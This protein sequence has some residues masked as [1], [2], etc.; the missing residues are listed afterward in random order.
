MMYAQS[1]PWVAI[2]AFIVGSACFVGL[3]VRALR[4]GKKQEG[5]WI[6]A[7]AMAML[8][9]GLALWL[10]WDKFANV[11]ISHAISFIPM[12]AM[13]YCVIQAERFRL[14]VPYRF[15]A[16]MV[17]LGIGFVV[18]GLVLVHLL[19]FPEDPWVVA[20][21][22]PLVGAAAAAIFVVDIILHERLHKR[23]MQ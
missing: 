20:I 6:A 22:N 14:G 23:S 8:G 3:S 7:G 21:A 9:I 18:N 2:V 4:R 1:P 16:S 12:Y 15:T 5:Q 11:F 10:L 17:A 13:L 19:G